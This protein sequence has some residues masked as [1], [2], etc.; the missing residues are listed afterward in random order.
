MYSCVSHS[1]LGM[2]SC[3]SHSGL[4]ICPNISHFFLV[5]VPMC[6][7]HWYGICLNAPH[8]FFGLCPNASHSKQCVPLCVPTSCDDTDGGLRS[9]VSYF[10]AFQRFLLSRVS[11]FPAFQRFLCLLLT[12]I[13]VL[14]PSS[15]VFFR[16]ALNEWKPLG[17]GRLD[18]SLQIKETTV[19]MNVK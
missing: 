3:V 12:E 8:N 16:L 10:P 14:V 17:P 19:S 7:Q 4:G 13:L 5:C 18:L 6:L 9:S 1:G 15:P 11:Y 2:C